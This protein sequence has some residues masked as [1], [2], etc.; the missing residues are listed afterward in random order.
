MSMEEFSNIKPFKGRVVSVEKIPYEPHYP[1][2]SISGPDFRVRVARSNGSI[3]VINRI[4]TTMPTKDR[5]LEG[6]KDK[7][8]CA[9]PEEILECEDKPEPPG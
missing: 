6:L 4:H 2:R 3:I 1:L 7:R 5:R 8:E 9:L